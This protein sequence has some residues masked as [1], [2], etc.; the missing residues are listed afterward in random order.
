MSQKAIFINFTFVL[1]NSRRIVI[2]KSV[3]IVGNVHNQSKG[4]AHPSDNLLK[5]NFNL[6][7]NEAPGMPRNRS[8]SMFSLMDREAS[9]G[10]TTNCNGMTDEQLA[11]A[12]SAA[13]A[14]PQIF[15]ADG[16]LDEELGEDQ[17][18][19]HQARFQPRMHVAVKP[20]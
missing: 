16:L 20:E 7:F 4:P 3:R 9:N 2:F 14:S 13:P 5:C 10:G 15:Y 19:P 11:L 1:C 12:A 8:P 18:S 17:L 6:K